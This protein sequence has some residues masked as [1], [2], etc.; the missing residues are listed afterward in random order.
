MSKF[1]CPISHSK[2][3]KKI[4]SIK[5][6]P[7]FMGVA[8]YNKNY[9]FANLNWW[10][11]KDT[12][13]VQI[14][15]KLSLEKMYFKG[16]GAGTIGK[17]WKDHHR[18]FFNIVRP[19]LKG[20]VCEIGG[21]SNSII[22]KIYNFNEINKFYSF[23]ANLRVNKENKKIIKIKKFFYSDYFVKNNNIKIDLLVHSHLFEHMLDPGK[24]L[25]I[26]NLI[27]SKN[28]KHIFAIPNM[29][30]MIKKG[31]ANAMN[32]EHPFYF[33]EKL[34]DT[35]L[36]KNH[37]KIIK[38]NYFKD[39]HSIMYVTKK[40]INK[41]QLNKN[42]SSN[43]SQYKKNLKLFNGMFDLWKNDIA[44]IN[45]FIKNYE[46]VY[47]FGAHIFSQMM[48]FNQLNLKNIK[49]ILDNDKKKIKNYLYGT[50]FKIYGPTQLK[51]ILYPCVI[52]R[53]G[54][55]NQ[56]IKNQLIKINKNVRII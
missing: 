3:F 47:V 22:N 30:P 43:Y 17:V 53:A 1:F 44:K 56:E 39:D 33:D 11:N 13:N 35:L 23:D 38:K 7:T 42:K 41:N 26:V 48:I 49:G 28:G 34:V 27:L 16:H 21:G 2:R 25:N 52:L 20:N 4:F 18:L 37:F 46:N 24:F 12:G 9:K 19:H 31:Y 32:F 36:Y 50:D 40:I 5:K 8:K 45:K 6:F 55:Y 14:Y 29:K 51:K 54:S 10:I 15:P